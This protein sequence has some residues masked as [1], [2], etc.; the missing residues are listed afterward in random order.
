MRYNNPLLASLYTVP[1]RTHPGAQ[2]AEI[3][4]VIPDPV[5]IHSSLPCTDPGGHLAQ[6][7]PVQVCVYACTCAFVCV[8][9]CFCFTLVVRVRSRLLCVC[10]CA[11]A[12]R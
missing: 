5:N 1:Y 3:L 11:S 2:I 10:M 4:K 6:P 8:H 9:V 7:V 12:S